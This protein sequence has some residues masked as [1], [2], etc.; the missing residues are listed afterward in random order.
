[1]SLPWLEPHQQRLGAAVAANQLGHAPMLLGSRGVGKRALAEWLVRMLLCNAAGSDAPPC[2]RCRACRAIDSGAHPDLF[3][4]EPPEDKHEIR[5]DQVREFIA[6]L[7]L[8]PALGSRRAG[9][10]VPADALNRNAANALLKTLEEPADEAWIVLVTDRED[11]LPATILSRCQRHI[12]AT[13]PATEVGDWLAARHADRS[14][15]DC[16][17]ALALAD[18]APLTADRWLTGDELTQGLAI[19][20]ALAGLL[21]GRG[22]LPGLAEDWSRSPAVTW[23]WLARW[24]EMWMQ[25]LLARRPPALGEAALPAGAAAPRRLEA[26]W[27]L[28]LEGVRMVERPVRHD[29]LMLEWLTAWRRLAAGASVRA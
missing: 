25:A 2:G 19:R 27:K 10:I 13:P 14:P 9:L 23:P 16:R 5:V 15:A 4:L 7:E 3:R 11:R 29:L 18:G 28:A 8:T 26:C 24:S 20:D 22:D 21:A 1:M 17:Q 6:A 12:V